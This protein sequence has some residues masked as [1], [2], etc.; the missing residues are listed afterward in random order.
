MSE[1]AEMPGQVPIVPPSAEEDAAAEPPSE[2]AEQPPPS[3]ADDRKKHWRRRAICRTCCWLLFPFA[4]LAVYVFVVEVYLR[5]HSF[6]GCE[7]EWALELTVPLALDVTG[8]D[9]N[10]R[11]APEGEPASPTTSTPASSRT[12][13]RG[14]SSSVLHGG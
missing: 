2:P 6:L 14:A 12:R 10:M 8:C 5:C 11:P 7:N 9:V 1:A 13:A 4:F 3:P